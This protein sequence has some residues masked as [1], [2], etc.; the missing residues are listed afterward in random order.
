M[1]PPNKNQHALVNFFRE[2]GND[3]SRAIQRPMVHFHFIS[4]LTI[5]WNGTPIV[6]SSF[7]NNRCKLA[8]LN[9]RHYKRNPYIIALVQ[10]MHS[11]IR[12]TGQTR[13]PEEIR[14]HCNNF[15]RQRNF[16]HFMAFCNELMSRGIVKAVYLNHNAG[17][18]IPG[19]IHDQAD[20][21]GSSN[22][23]KTH[24]LT[25]IRSHEK[26]LGS[27]LRIIDYHRRY[28]HT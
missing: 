3:P 8:F 24:I 14:V 23:C 18:T 21:V 17:D 15:I 25:G 7:E 19:Y 5:T 10:T 9:V 11:S 16:D 27:A 6:D 26:I 1:L 22:A 4:D 13:L 2:L 20:K 12:S 28:G